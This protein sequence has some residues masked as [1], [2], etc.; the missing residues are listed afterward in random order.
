[1][2]EGEVLYI[3]A[4]REGYLDSVRKRTGQ[5]D[6]PPDAHAEAQ[7]AAERAAL[8]LDPEQ[9]DNPAMGYTHGRYHGWH[10]KLSPGAYQR[11][12]QN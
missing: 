8:G 9:L 12:K 11:A 4:Y 10:G 2:D 5:G 1:M 6:L 7:A 3:Q